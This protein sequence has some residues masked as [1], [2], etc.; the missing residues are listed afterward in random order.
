MWI[1]GYPSFK[2]CSFIWYTGEA[3]RDLISLCPS[4]NLSPIIDLH[5][6][7]AVVTQFHHI[8]SGIYLVHNSFTP[9]DHTE[10]STSFNLLILSPWSLHWLLVNLT[11]GT[12]SYN[13]PHS[14]CPFE[15]LTYLLEAKFL[16]G[17]DFTFTSLYCFTFTVP[18][19]HK[20]MI[21]WCLDMYIIVCDPLQEVF[22]SS[23]ST[24]I[25]Y[26]GSAK[27]PG[28]GNGN[29]LRYSCLEVAWTQEPDG[30]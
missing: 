4:S 13:S 21:Y 12:F 5:K 19:A 1:Y 30:L 7:Q 28:E 20:Y 18:L 10:H 6:D 2:K 24:I 16:K 22:N 23:F 26:K 11:R 3:L 25:L 9:L 29:P 27:S 8:L 17:Q 15:Y 14:D